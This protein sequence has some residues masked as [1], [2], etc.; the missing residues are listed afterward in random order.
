M[1]VNAN[2]NGGIQSP[3]SQVLA[4]ATTT[5]IGSTATD[6]SLILASWAIT[7]DTGGTVN[8]YLYWY[9]ASAATEYLIWQ[10]PLAT[11]DTAVESN[12][13]VNLRTGDEIRAKG[14][15]TVTVTLIYTASFPNGVQS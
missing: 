12:L 4:G 11:K 2:Y 14:A 7:N 13:P 5:K 3:V 10:K 9:S 6:N 1:S 8:V 15:A